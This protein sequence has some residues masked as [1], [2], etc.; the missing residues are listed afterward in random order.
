MVKVKEALYY[1]KLEDNRVRCKLCPHKCLLG[2]GKTGICRV[3]KNEGGKLYS[4]NYEKITSFAIDPIEKKP[5][6]HFYPGSKIASI[7]TFGCNFKCSF[8]QNY[9][10]SQLD[11]EYNT[12]T[13]CQMMEMVENYK[14]NL[15]LAYTYNE[16][17]IWYEYVI[18]MAQKVKEKKMKNVLVTN[19]YIEEAPLREILPYIDALNIDLKSFNDEFYPKI[20]KGSREEV[21]R[22]IEISNEHAHVEIATLLI[23]GLNTDAKEIDELAR[24]LSSVNK[25][26]PLHLDRYFPAYKMD[27]PATS[28]DRIM[29]LKE[30]AKKHLNYVYIGNVLDVDR[31]TYCPNCGVVIVDRA[32]KVKVQN[33]KD[34]KC[35]N[36]RQEINL[37]TG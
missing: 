30:V 2:D 37:I 1:E 28:I 13:S 31:N 34:G 29:E 15:G 10:I 21:M 17:T 20:C 19:G 24:W 18:E 32:E 4:L 36:C 26:I 27:I 14:D 3:R 9:R 8:C 25:D 11:P 12:V 35:T 33:F 5:L 16:P 23:E 6:Y 22:S 7:G